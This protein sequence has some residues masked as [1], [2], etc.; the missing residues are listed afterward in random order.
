MYGDSSHKAEGVCVWEK[1]GEMQGVRWVN[2]TTKA[3]DDYL[4]YSYVLQ[5]YTGPVN[6]NHI[7]DLDD[8]NFTFNKRVLGIIDIETGTRTE[9]TINAA[10][11]G[12]IYTDFD[13]S[14]SAA[15]GLHI[16]KRG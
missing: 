14:L 9:H 8:T 10:A 7:D 3:T 4:F 11:K 2:C 1:T 16:L 13:E 12:D 6:E 5:D 15:V